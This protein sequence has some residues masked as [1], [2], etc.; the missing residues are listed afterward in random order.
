MEEVRCLLCGK[1]CAAGLHIMGCLI[2]FHCEKRMLGSRASLRIPARKRR[3]LSRL[4][5]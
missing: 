2:C 4:Y 5:G 3:A 1:T